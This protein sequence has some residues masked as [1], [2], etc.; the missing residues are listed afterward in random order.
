MNKADYCALLSQRLAKYFDVTQ[1]GA[2]GGKTY[3]IT[4]SYAARENQTVLFKENVMDYSESNEICLVSVTGSEDGAAASERDALS[5]AAVR[6]DLLSLPQTALYL[7]GTVSRHH[8]STT[9]LRVFVCESKAPKEIVRAVTRFSWSKSFR[10]GFFG[11]ASVKTVLVDLE[12]SRV[13]TNGAARDVK[14]MF[15]P[16]YTE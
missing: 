1:N 10:F 12:Q 4:A 8:K 9:V 14:A 11:W 13:W 5:S 6:Q 15:I 3:D 16:L 7:A 2:Y